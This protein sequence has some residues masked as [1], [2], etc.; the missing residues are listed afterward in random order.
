MS[1]NTAEL[2]R[3]DSLPQ[4]VLHLDADAFFASVEQALNPALKGLPVVTGKERGIIACAS[5]E[6]KALGVRRPMPMHEARRICPTLVC[7]PSDYETYSLFSKRMFGIIR[8]FTPTVEEYSIDEAFAEL[9]GLRRVYRTGYPEIARRIKETVQRELGITVSVGLS[10]SKTLAKMAAKEKKPDGFV[11]VTGRELHGFLEKMPLERVCGFGPNTRALLHK[12]GVATVLD[13]V[14]RDECWARSLLGK[15]GVELWHELRGDAVYGFQTGEK[16]DYASI[17]KTKT[18]SLPSDK[19][20]FVRAQVVRNLESALIK[21]RR[22]RLRAA[23]LTVFLKTREFR[24]RGL[25]AELDRATASTLA[26]VPLAC[27]LF[28]DLF[29]AGVVYR[30]TGVVLSKIE[31]DGVSGQY[32]LFENPAGVRSLRAIDR[33][34]DGV[35]EIYGKHTLGLATD[36]WISNRACPATAGQKVRVSERQ[37]LSHAAKRGTI[38]Q[39]GSLPDRLELPGR[40]KQLLPGETFRQ[41]LNIPIWQVS[42]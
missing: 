40:K 2:I 36:L 14:R 23:R 12:Q 33:V 16:H 31:P 27:R 17:S 7:L 37:E 10:L 35:N 13:Y 38:V 9:S 6:A 32:L 3:I 25:E 28:E 22:H 24:T 41:R 18:F 1:E 42:V 34:I 5:Y 21:L 30:A 20:D 11:T 4:A 26:V 8:R 15:I 19:K 39:S 29:E